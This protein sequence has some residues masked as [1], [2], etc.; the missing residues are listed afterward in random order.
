MH[1]H[2]RLIVIQVFVVGSEIR[3]F[4][5]IECISEIQGRPRSLILAPIERAYATSY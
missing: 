5:A 3:I 4:S 1:S 2:E